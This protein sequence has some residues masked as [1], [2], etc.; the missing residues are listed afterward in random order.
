MPQLALG[1]AQFGLRYGITNAEGK[2]AP[3]LACTLLKQASEAGV[4]FIDTAQA[5]GDA[6]Q[7]LGDA[8][9]SCHSFRVISKL[10]AQPADQPF[11]AATEVRWQRSLEL[12]LE[13]LQLSQI[14]GL[15]LHAAGDLARA[16]GSRL[17]NW[18]RT[19]QQRGQVRR[20]GVSIYAASDLEGLPLDD[21][22]LVQIPCSLY[23][24]RLLVDGTVDTL[25][26]QGIAVHARSLYLQGLLVTPPECWSE[27]IAPALRHHHEKLQGWAQR[28]GWS[29]VQLAL[30]WA[31]RQAWMEAAVVG[32]TSESELNQLCGAWRGPDPWQ[33]QQP[34]SWAWPFGSDLDPRQWG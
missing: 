15:L 30:T 29:L 27:V 11:D 34:E 1:T 16:D 33:D 24:Q 25:R 5:Y 3:A 26:S 21:L 18:M 22:Q 10:P 31:R 28:N 7:V 4:A 17:L 14:D 19:V 13:R 32:V 6:E 2:V 8:M 23:D 12:T 20:I 9:P